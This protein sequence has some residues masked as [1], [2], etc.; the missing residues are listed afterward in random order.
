MRSLVGG[1][2]M[3][4]LALVWALVTWLWVPEAAESSPLPVVMVG[5]SGVL[6]LAHGLISRRRR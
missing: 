4:T 3:L 2:A 5:I 1:A 6:F